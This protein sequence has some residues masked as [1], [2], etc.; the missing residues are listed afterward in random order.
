MSEMSEMMAFSGP[1]ANPLHSKMTGEHITQTLELAHKHDE[2]EYNLQDRRLEIQAS[3]RYFRI[4]IFGM[5]LLAF[6]ALVWLFRDKPDVL[7]PLLTGLGGLVSGFAA[8]WGYG[9]GGSDD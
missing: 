4:A 7:I 3:S 6:M 9:R 8:G 5:S 2:R 1:M